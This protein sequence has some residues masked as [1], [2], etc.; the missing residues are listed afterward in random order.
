MTIQ[1]YSVEQTVAN[2]F[3]VQQFI[4]FLNDVIRNRFARDGVFMKLSKQT[5]V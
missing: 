5:T 2:V 4:L 3:N 1:A